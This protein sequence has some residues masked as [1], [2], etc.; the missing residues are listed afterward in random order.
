VV[1]LDGAPVAT[2]PALKTAADQM[3]TD[4]SLQAP[5]DAAQPKTSDPHQPS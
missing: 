1:A 2:D 4:S 3:F 5:V